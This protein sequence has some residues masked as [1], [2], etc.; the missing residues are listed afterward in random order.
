VLVSQVKGR[1]TKASKKP[2]KKKPEV[3]PKRPKPETKPARKKPEA[4]P[5]P[6]KPEVTPRPDKPEVT[7]VPDKPEM[8]DTD[9]PTFTLLIPT[10]NEIV[11]MKA[12]MPLIDRSWV[13]QIL[14]VDGNS[15]DGTAEWARDQGYDVYVQ[16][17]KGIRH[18]YIEALP[19]I[20]GDITITFSPDGNSIAELI[21]P[22]CAK[23][24]EGYDMVIVSRYLDDAKS[25]DD[26]VITGFGN[27]LFN[28][29]I[30]RLHGGNYTDCMVMYRAWRTSLFTEL[31][32]HR[33]DAYA[34]ERWWGT[35]LGCEPLLSV[36]AAKAGL[37]ITEI[38]G[39]EP[40]RLGG[41][42][43]LQIVRWGGA[44]MS[45]IFRELYFWR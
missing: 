16:K 32:L 1:K 30:N 8:P 7:P 27:W 21:P 3:T 22:L 35:V 15:T 19:L 14:V 4:R 13:D 39:D 10:L 20:K 37:R 12:I 34:P 29:V 45:Q 24:R 26:D 18:A 38:P 41:E 42:R 9:E 43:K 31:G 5:G 28:R 23:M 17:R 6:D 44:Y 40:P 25:D 36:R 2:T 11:G 33:E